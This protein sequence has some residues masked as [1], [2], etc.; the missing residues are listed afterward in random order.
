MTRIIPKGQLAK[1]EILKGIELDE[2]APLLDACDELMFQ[3]DDV[4]L[5]SGHHERAL[6]LLLMGQATVTIDSTEQA[7]QWVAEIGAGSVVGE[8]SFLHPA[9]HSATVTSRASCTFLRLDRARF[10]KVAEQHPA[11]ASRL[12]LN[13]AELLAARLQAADIWMS[14]WL[15][16]AEK[17]RLQ[18]RAG[19]LR[20]A[21][22]MRAPSTSVFLGLNWN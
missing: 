16:S 10:D 8:M 19:Q 6:W 4:V 20:Q 11:L 3:P 15:A 18:E 14:E 2:L 13:I 7:S 1:F 21:F 17:S 12:I 22:A 5:T 9:P